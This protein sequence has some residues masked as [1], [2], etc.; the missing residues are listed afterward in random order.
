MANSRHRR[1]RRTKKLGELK[2]YL[3]IALGTFVVAAAIS[4]V[5]G[6]VPAFVENVLNKQIQ[7]AISEKAGQL[8]PEA[9][10]QD[11][12]MRAEIERLKREMKGKR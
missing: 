3:L 10:V 2:V 1:K 7:S 4:F 5:T 12:A 9:A 8:T 6:Q 11:P